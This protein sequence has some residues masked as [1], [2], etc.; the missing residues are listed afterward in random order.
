MRTVRRRTDRKRAASWKSTTFAGVA[1]AASLAFGSRDAQASVVCDLDAAKQYQVT[2]ATRKSY[3]GLQPCFE[4]GSQRMRPLVKWSNKRGGLGCSVSI[5]P[6]GV[7]CSID[8]WRSE[9]DFN[10]IDLD[11]SMWGP[12]GVF[13]WSCPIDAGDVSSHNDYQFTCVGPWFTDPGN[14]A[15]WA[16]TTFDVKDDG[17]GSFAFTSGIMQRVK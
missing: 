13:D 7:G 2:T 1:A 16:D 4:T 10:S 11:M 12:P 8:A 15:T 5:Y 17:N 9:V 14:Y 3:V 6:P